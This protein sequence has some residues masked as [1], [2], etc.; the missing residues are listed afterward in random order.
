M[1]PRL[2]IYQNADECPAPVRYQT[3]LLDLRLCDNMELMR[4]YPDGYF[5]LAIVDPPYGI[6][7]DGHRGDKKHGWKKHSF[8]GWDNAPPPKEYF[9]ELFRVS[10]NQIIC[11]ANYFTQYLPAS[12]GWV[13]WCKG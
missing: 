2:N 8:G 11:G 4:Q 12:K 7:R 1:P 6:K 10:Q 5:G 3:D 9:D 13:Y